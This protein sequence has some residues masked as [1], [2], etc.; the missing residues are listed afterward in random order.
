MARKAAPVLPKGR[1]GTAARV[2]LG[3]GGNADRRAASVAGGDVSGREGRA[4]GGLG[5]DLQG[6]HEIVQNFRFLV[7]H[8]AKFLVEK[9]EVG[10]DAVEVG[11][12]GQEH[13]LPK[14]GVIQVSDHVK[15][16]SVD[17]LHD[18]LKGAWEVV[19]WNQNTS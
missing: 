8:E 2:A 12:E 4:V 10:E 16:Q 14:V 11:V 5:V 6:E 18:R 3:R 7:V 17:L 19:I 13:D 15:Q 9:N 1:R